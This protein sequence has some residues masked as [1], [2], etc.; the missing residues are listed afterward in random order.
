MGATLFRFESC[1]A[2]H[3]YFQWLTEVIRSLIE[4]PS[5]PMNEGGDKVAT[6]QEAKTSNSS[7]RKSGPHAKVKAGSAV[8]PIY[9]SK[10]GDRVRYAVSFYR[11]GKRLR[12]MF[13]TLDAAKKEA[14]FVAQRIQVGM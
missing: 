11:D 14:R 8:V 4:T 12:K 13:S 3:F 5:R 10:S 2:H 7:G 1:R 9:Q 6:N